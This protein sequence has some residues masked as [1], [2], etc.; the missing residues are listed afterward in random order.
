MA[1]GT[2]V[3]YPPDYEDIDDVSRTPDEEAT[4][5]DIRDDIE[6]TRADMSETIDAIQ[7]KFSPERLKDQAKESVRAATVGRAEQ[8]VS[9]A[10]E[11]ARQAGGSFIETI[12]QNPI[13]AAL[14]A[15]GAGWLWRSRQSTSRSQQ[16]Y[17]RSYYREPYPSGRGYGGSYAGGHEE[18]GG[19]GQAAGRVQ[20]R[21]G[22][23]ASP[24]QSQAGQT[25]EQAQQRVGEWSGQAQQQ[26]R[27][28]RS[29]FDRLLDE[30][31][32][33]VAVAAFGLG[34]AVGLALP[35]TQREHEMMGPARDTMMEKAQSAAQ[36][37][38]EKVSEVADTAQQ[39]AQQK[40]EEQGLTQP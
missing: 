38:M 36:Q 6:A 24:V 4:P 17:L 12:K 14:V 21:A 40:A 5:E 11:S 16:E 27:S 25:M 33:G 8:A 30:N 20:E 28:A 29:Q 39:A 18:A 31:P 22:E 7:E 23:M 15:L 19:V 35:E 3:N 10:S 1:E 37:T 13:P 34:A 2:G 32:L 26:M 9:D